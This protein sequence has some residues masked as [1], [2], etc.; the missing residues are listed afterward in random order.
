MDEEQQE[1]EEEVVEA[2]EISGGEERERGRDWEGGPA[3]R[4][5]GVR[6]EIRVRKMGGAVLF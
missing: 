2:E 5:G 4:D 1:E 3:E 6:G